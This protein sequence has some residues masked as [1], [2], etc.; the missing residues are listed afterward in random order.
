MTF[1]QLINKC[2]SAA[3]AEL[4]SPVHSSIMPQAMDA[5]LPLLSPGATILDIGIGSGMSMDLL[6]RRG[7]YPFGISI[8][9]SEVDAARFRG[10]DAECMDMHYIDRLAPK[11]FDCV[12]A[13]HVLEHSPCPLLMF[14]LILDRLKPGGWLYCEV[15]APD[16]SAHHQSNPNHYSVM[17]LS[18][19]YCLMLKAGFVSIK[20]QEIKFEIII[21]D[22]C[23]FALAA[24]KP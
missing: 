21:G 15:P 22:D 14:H 13:R 12:W 3:Y 6:T 2:G 5:F 20:T 19:W 16:T 17:Q 8:L 1:E 18:G 7:F 23:Y 9:Q 4:D 24:Q 10:F 11:V